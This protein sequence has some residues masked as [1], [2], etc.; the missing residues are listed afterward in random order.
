MGL[1]R[2]LKRVLWGFE[3]HSKR[4]YSPFFWNNP[5]L[6]LLVSRFQFHAAPIFFRCSSTRPASASASQVSVGNGMA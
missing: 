4:L 2:A 6:G 1:Q 5:G 3:I